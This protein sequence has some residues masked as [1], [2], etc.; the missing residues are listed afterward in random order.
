MQ[1]TL[2]HPRTVHLTAE[3]IIRSPWGQ[4]AQRVYGARCAGLPDEDVALL[5]DWE[6]RGLIPS[7]N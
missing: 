3:Q 5:V 4:A 1:Q 2:T 7:R 6:L